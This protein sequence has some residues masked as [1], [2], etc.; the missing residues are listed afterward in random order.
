MK[1]TAGLTSASGTFEF[2]VSA[3]LR[4]ETQCW[5]FITAGWHFPWV[6]NAGNSCCPWGIMAQQKTTHSS[7]GVYWGGGGGGGAGLLQ[8][9]CFWVISMQQETFKSIFVTRQV[10]F[11]GNG[12]VGVQC[13]TQF[14]S[15]VSYVEVTH[16]LPSNVSEPKFDMRREIWT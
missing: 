1:D 9:S 10:M 8:R 2:C 15:Y 12:A 14:V 13:T 5:L 7:V 16:L 3:L 4:R 11:E 6:S